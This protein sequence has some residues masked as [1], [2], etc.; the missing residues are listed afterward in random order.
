MRES[1]AFIR[2]LPLRRRFYD[3][4]EIALVTAAKLIDD[5]ATLKSGAEYMECH[6]S[7]DPAQAR[8]YALW[9]ELISRGPK[10][11]VRELLADTDR[12]ALLR[13]TCPV[14]YVL[15]GAERE[16]ALARARKEYRETA[17]DVFGS[18]LPDETLADVFDQRR[19]S[20]W[21]E[22]DL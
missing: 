7:A 22:V 3:R 9:K 2:S 21:R 1:E 6:M 5:P 20:D 12:G 13:E 14:F 17:F 4:N 15:A 11:I 10:E 18:E 16:Q 19:Q 8:Y